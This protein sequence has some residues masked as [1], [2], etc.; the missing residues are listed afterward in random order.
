MKYIDEFRDGELAKNLAA[1]IAATVERRY[2]SPSASSVM[3]IV[4]TFCTSSSFN[5]NMWTP[6]QSPIGW[7]ASIGD[8]IWQTCRYIGMFRHKTLGG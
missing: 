4:S 8:L 7:T 3:G 6:Y 1:S 2:V 5:N